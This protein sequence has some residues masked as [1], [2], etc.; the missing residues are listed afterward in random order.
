[1]KK[2]FFFLIIFHFITLINGQS[3]NLNQSSIIENIRDQQLIG[4][5]SSDLSF[6]IKPISLENFDIDEIQ[7]LK[8]QNY[9]PS[10]LNFLNGKINFKILPIDYNL[11]FNSNHPY[12]RNNGTMIP[13]KGY[14]HVF[15]PGLYAKI[16]PL[17]ITLKP[18]H[19]FAENKNF[20]GFWEGHRDVI[21]ERRYR[22]W[23]TIDI[24]EK[25]GDKN[26]NSTYIGQSS[27]R[28][29][30]K[31]LSLGISNE[32]IWWGPSIRNSIMMSNHAR[33]FKHITFNTIKPVETKIGN[34][35]WQLISARLESS[36]YN[37]SGY[38]RKNAGIPI[39]I[40]KINQ[41]AET[42]D[43]RYMQALMFS[44]SPKWIDGLSLGYIRW[45]QFYSAL[46]EGRYYW[47]DGNTGYFPV[48][49]NLFRKND[50][51]ASHEAQIDQAAGLFFRWLWKESN[52]EI[53]TEYH[54]N[55]SKVNLRDLL[56]DSRHARAFTIGLQKYFLKSSIKFNFEWTQ[57]EQTGGR[58]IREA[59]S[60]YQHFQVYDGY[61]NRGEVLGS[62]IGPGSNS[63]YISLTKFK[64]NS[65]ITL[66]F[67]IIHHDN[68]FYYM[69]FESSKDFRRYWKDYNINLKYQT[70]F[71]NL[72][73]A[74]DAFY[75]R[76][77][78]YQW[79]LEE[80]PTKYYIPGIDKN[81]FHLSL[82]LS[83]EIPLAN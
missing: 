11:E 18:E 25:F 83:Y 30:F 47:M 32:N 55:D 15:S 60:F 4:N 61:T 8:L 35:E 71:K 79:G 41:L 29:N 23:N 72:W 48:F 6:N 51:S 5:I 9:A 50:K 74:M 39:Y 10:F 19:H 76:S 28:L 54:F 7:T 58:L 2:Q 64:E 75:I 13:N 66:G 37:Q 45:V 26:H 78:N 3:I 65:K 22:L 70:K 20:E 16:G 33:G 56:L 46:V 77:L 36:G 44:Y 17:E 1:M 80:D 21:W 59:G 57:M 43:W 14:Q 24:P 49:S 31:N 69:A 73:L 27:I 62:S 52:A 81:N 12:N 67:E 82:K 34:F 42:D 38:E 40:P 53:Y 68:D 63:Q